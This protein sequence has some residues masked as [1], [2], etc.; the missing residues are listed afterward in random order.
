[1][2]A[3]FPRDIAPTGIPGLDDV[4]SGG[5][6]KNR[7]YLVTGDPGVGKTTLGLHFLLE[8]AR[9]GERVLYITLSETREEIESV[10]A[11]HGWSLG[12]IDIFEY[13][14]A[15]RLDDEDESTIFH[16]SEIEL[17][18]ATRTIVSQVD[19]V[20]PQRVVIDSLS[21]VRLLAQNPLRYRRQILALKHYFAGKNCTVLLL[22]DKDVASGDM[23]LMTL[24]HGVILLE[25]LAPLYGAER[26][27]LR[28][29]KL[30]GVKYRG[31]FH[32]F[33]IRTGGLA[34][35]PRL[36][37]AEHHQLTESR[38]LTSGIP[39][40]DALLGGGIDRGT[41][42]LVMGPAG[43]GKSALTGQYAITAAQ[44]GENV[45]IFLFDES[46]ATMLARAHGIG[47]QMQPHIESGRIT[48]QQIDPAEV[49]PGE[50]VYLVR[51]AVEE[52]KVSILII[53]SLNG[54]LNAMPE[55]RFL[56]IQMHELLTYLGQQGVATL[57][58][59]AQHG[60]VA[61]A[62]T[63]PVDVSYLADCVV[64]LRYFEL[65]GEIRKAVSVVK[66][67]SGAHEKAIRPL[68]IT[69][70]GLMVGPP[71]T[72]FH[73]VLSGTPLVEAHVSGGVGDMLPG[74]RSK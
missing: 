42:T 59:V 39:A 48:V 55:E 61:T 64:L 63:S 4:L 24:A 27:R 30:R 14:A 58:V 29:S 9:L 21:E 72:E 71:L 69:S 22:D 3:Q 54:Y 73:G 38:Q 56:L 62:M 37:A 6:T 41:S 23:Q 7:I 46:R 5:L 47:M 31:G 17:G 8:G 11:S 10:A 2:T 74:G 35:F 36:V 19:S 66:K 40:I 53:D 49:P 28:V 1:M 50:F 45:A 12:G 25:Q 13:S 60:V 44:R 15:A 57:L 67:R 51:E 32:D 18:E 68:S 70:E 65:A 33:L 26:R 43:S 34:V 20:Q 52:R 16:P